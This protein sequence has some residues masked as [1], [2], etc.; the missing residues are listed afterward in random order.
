MK[1]IALLA[2]ILCACATSSAHRATVTIVQKPLNK[3]A[4]SVTNTS[5]ASLILRS[6][7][8]DEIGEGEK[9]AQGSVHIATQIVNESLPPFASK[10]VAFW[11]STGMSKS[12][13]YESAREST[14]R[15]TAHFDTFDVS[16]SLT[17]TQR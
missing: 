11:A 3:F 15:A 4:V 9:I 10:E 13:P 14:F 6:V 17:V 8:V 16:Q 12:V 7:D 2:L 1:R 5:A